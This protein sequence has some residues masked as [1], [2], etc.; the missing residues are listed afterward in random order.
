M[1]DVSHGAFS[2]CLDY[3]FAEGSQKEQ[4]HQDNIFDSFIKQTD[5]PEILKKYNFDVDYIIDD[6]NFPLK[7]TTLP[8]ICADRIDY[9]LRDGSCRGEIAPVDV[10]FILDRLTV[11]DNKRIFQD[12]ESAKK[13]TLLAQN[14]NDMYMSGIEAAAMYQAVGDC[15]KYAWQK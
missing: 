4:N 11:V 7:E 9:T 10:S 14:L 2:H 5:I 6:T 12:F 3:V 15:F 1:H 8:E 13:Y